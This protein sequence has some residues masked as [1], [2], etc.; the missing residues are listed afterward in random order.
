MSLSGQSWH[1]VNVDLSWSEIYTSC[2]VI[3]LG[4]AESEEVM[5]L[6]M[7]VFVRVCLSAVLAKYLINHWMD[8]NETR[9]KQGFDVYF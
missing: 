3:R 7:S 6:F 9:R 1:G 8:L 2:Q 5:F 4:L